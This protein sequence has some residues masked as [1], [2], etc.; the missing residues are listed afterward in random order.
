MELGEEV[1]EDIVEEV[2]FFQ[3]ENAF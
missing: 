2:K 3:D 1:D